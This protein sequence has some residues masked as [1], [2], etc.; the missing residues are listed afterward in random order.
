MFKRM[1]LITALLCFG[2][3][4]ATAQAG[5]PTRTD[6]QPVSLVL[7]QNSYFGG[8]FDRPLFIAFGDGTVIYPT[9]RQYGVPTAYARAKLSPSTL[10]SLLIACGLRSALA[11]PD[12]A[13][14]LAPMMSDQLSLYLLTALDSGQRIVHFRAPYRSRDTLDQRIPEAWRTLLVHLGTF[15][16]SRSTPWVPDSVEVAIWPYDYAP[17]N[18][19]LAWPREWP[20]LSSSRWTRRDDQFVREVRLLR[21]PFSAVPRL[22]SLLASRREKQ[23]VGIGGR[24]WALRYRWIFPD[25]AAWRDLID[26]MAS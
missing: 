5:R 13:F 12:S 10:D 19:P 17:D 26:P 11:L 18:P 8:G 1:L 3:R 16:A 23:A 2:H 7:L 24:K 20:P 9:R 14:D 15:R 6:E 25:E 4:G 21:L 22:D